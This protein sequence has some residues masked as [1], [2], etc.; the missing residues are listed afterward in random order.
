MPVSD[1][2][3]CQRLVGVSTVNGYAFQHIQLSLMLPVHSPS[4]FTGCLW[5]RQTDNSPTRRCDFQPSTH[6]ILSFQ[7]LLGSS[8]AQPWNWKPIPRSFLH[9]VHELIWRQ[10]EIWRSVATDCRKLA[11]S[12]HC[13]PQLLTP[14]CN[15]V[16]PIT[17]WPSC[18]EVQ[19]LALLYNTANGWLWNI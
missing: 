7:L 4:G 1:L 5:L 17:L 3:L 11:T 2:V 8:A 13:A 9:T 10:H 18:W 16:W 14:L 12:V 15:F 6:F 19:W